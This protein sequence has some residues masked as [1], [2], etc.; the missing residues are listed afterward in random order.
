M[1]SKRR[2][3]K[4][5]RPGP[6]RRLSRD[7]T[8]EVVCRFFESI[9]TPVALA[10]KMLYIAGEHEQLANK[11]IDPSSYSDPEAFYLDYIATRF[12]TKHTGLVTGIDTTE[13]A[14]EEFLR[15]ERKCQVLNLQLTDLYIDDP[16]VALNSTTDWHFSR[17]VSWLQCKI[18]EVLG[19]LEWERVLDNCRFGPG[20]STRVRGT[21]TC[22]YE[23]FRGT[24]HSTHEALPF[25]LALSEQ[26]EN[27]PHRI[28]VTAGN[29]VTFVSKNAKTDRPIAIEPCMNQFMQLGLGGVMRDRLKRF[30]V[31]IRDQTRNQQFAYLGSI[32]GAFCTVDMKSASDLIS[33]SV[34]E[35]L[36]PDDWYQVLN[37]FRSKR[38]TLDGRGYSE[39]H[40][41]SSMGNG[42]TFP[43]QT[44]LFWSLAT[45]AAKMSNVGHAGVSAYGDDIIVPPEAFDTFLRLL[46]LFGFE[47]NSSKS[48]KAG[49]FRESCG[50]D[51]F[52]GRDCQPL[53]LKEPLLEGMDLV[54]FANR[55]RRLSIR[56]LS[57]HGCDKRFE[58]LWHYCVSQLPRD[59]QRCKIPEG[60][61]DCGLL[62]S[63]EEACP[64]KAPHVH[65]GNVYERGVPL[66]LE[67]YIYN[68]WVFLP[69]QYEMDDIGGTLRYALHSAEGIKSPERG[70][71]VASRI[72]DADEISGTDAIRD[73]DSAGGCP[74]GHKQAVHRR[75][76]SWV[77]R[78]GVAR[79]WPSLGGWF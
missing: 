12:L 28:E 33:R 60:Y 59:L 54:K 31:D 69:T 24:P 53:Y 45:L 52:V 67:G 25:V 4:A 18:S 77:R 17:I 41:F 15:C 49:P 27:F 11:R 26:W 32:T 74:N 70:W 42:F 30:G 66:G 40:K 65:D 44:L 14:I 20:S 22:A 10:C 56:S 47:P 9:D 39:Y 76:G 43:L 1:N 61:G 5:V 46:T 35:L 34:V 21:K 29:V 73:F 36:L 68:R 50:K 51:Y 48:F 75:K 13:V 3:G 8:P 58:A 79:N 63:F 2:K 37:A 6:V 23:K 64:Q 78:K 38:Y 72:S 7:L 55:L 57:G 16:V 71:V 19:P 62:V